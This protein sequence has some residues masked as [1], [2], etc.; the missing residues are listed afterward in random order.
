MRWGKWKLVARH[1][2]D[3]ARWELYDMEADRSESNDLADEERAP[4]VRRMVQ[5]YETWS[6]RCGVQPWPVK[7]PEPGGDR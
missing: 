4:L 7:R 1:R 2:R 5:L 3:G 6:R